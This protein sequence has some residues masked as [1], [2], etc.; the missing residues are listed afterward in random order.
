[1]VHEMLHLP[2]RPV[3]HVTAARLRPKRFNSH[4]T[5]LRMIHKST[6][7]VARAHVYEFALLLNRV[8][9][10]VDWTK[11]PRTSR[12]TDPPYKLYSTPRV[13]KGHPQIFAHVLLQDGRPKRMFEKHCTYQSNCMLVSVPFRYFQDSRNESEYK[14]TKYSQAM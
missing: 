2:L 1:M 8:H 11:R 14:I 7:Y 13:T 6:N 9:S 3:A 4:M 5:G 12:G 10:S